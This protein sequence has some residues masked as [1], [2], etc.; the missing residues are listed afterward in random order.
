M[1]VATAGCTLS[2]RTASLEGEQRRLRD[3]VAAL[4]LRVGE[5]EGKLAAL[6]KRVGT[7]ARRI[8]REREREVAETPAPEATSLWPA[9]SPTPIP[10][11]LP[12]L[13]VDGL[14][15]ESARQL[16]SGYQ[17]G[18]DRMRSGAYEDAIRILR[19]FVRTKHESPFVPGAHYWIGQAYLQLGQYY[20]AILAF[21]DVQQRSPRSEFAPAAGLASGSAFLQ[22][23]NVTEARRAFERV[24]ADHPSTPE[25]AKATARLRA[26]ESGGR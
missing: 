10:T 5:M 11:V 4:Q 14:Q 8:E 17:R 20:Q 15:R 9:P 25:A 6:S 3:E 26:L 23:G 21:T 18:I 24:A 13:D 1:L 2:T 19:D 7:T 16:P 12:E 22:L